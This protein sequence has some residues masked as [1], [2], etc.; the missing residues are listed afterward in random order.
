MID[1]DNWL[2][3]GGFV[4]F[5]T[6]F[7]YNGQRL[8]KI[9]KAMPTPWLVWVSNNRKSIYVLIALSGAASIYFL[10]EIS[11]TIKAANIALWSAMLISVLY[12]T[13]LSKMSLRSIPYLKIH[14]I[15]IS[16]SIVIILFPALNEAWNG[17]L[18]LLFLAHYF[19]VLG[20]TIPFDIR[21]L[22]FDSKSTKTIP[23]VV[24]ISV[25]RILAIFSIVAFSVI[26]LFLFQ[27]LWWNAFFYIAILTQIALVV[28]VNERST[29]IYCAGFI[30]GAIALLGAAYFL[31]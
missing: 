13:K 12:V 26:M 14:L 4:M 8:L 16:W 31:G 29:D 22:K 9:D 3:Y 2:F 17:Q 11:T 10:S 6:L 28:F 23:Q 7:V 21:D 1:A 18:L 15:A 30:D 24:G 19:Y 25:A 20:V 5:S 27:S